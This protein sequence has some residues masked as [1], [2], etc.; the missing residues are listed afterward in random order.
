ME[1]LSTLCLICALLSVA[2][3]LEF[4]SNID[5]LAS[6]LDAQDSIINYFATYTLNSAP[7]DFIGIYDSDFAIPDWNMSSFID[8]FN[9]ETSQMV[10]AEPSQMANVSIVERD[11]GT[12]DNTK[13]IECDPPKCLAKRN[14]G[15]KVARKDDVDDFRGCEALGQFIPVASGVIFALVGSATC[16]LPGGQVSCVVIFG[17]L[18]GFLGDIG[19]DRFLHTC[20]TEAL[21]STRD[22]KGHASNTECHKDDKDLRFTYT[23][24]KGNPGCKQVQPKKGHSQCKK[25]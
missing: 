19:K 3:S 1:I 23:G 2:Q 7:I 5:S 15:I 14:N 10:D 12:E 20:E 21:F 16:V 6:D 13:K 8:Y 17:A 22:C 25:V 4:D 9:N 18:G 11:A 24:R